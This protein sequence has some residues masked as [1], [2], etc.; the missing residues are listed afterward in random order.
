VWFAKPDETTTFHMLN[1]PAG[2][3]DMDLAP[4]G[5]RYACA[6]S[7]GNTYV[8]TFTPLRPGEKPVTPTPKK[9]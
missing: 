8:Y 9:K 2:N 4:D 7:N 5:S 3:R 1:T 6:A